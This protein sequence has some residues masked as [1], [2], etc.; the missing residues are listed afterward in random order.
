MRYHLVQPMGG[1]TYRQATV[2]STHEN[3]CGLGR[4]DTQPVIV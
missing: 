1:D 2:I 4:P 3:G